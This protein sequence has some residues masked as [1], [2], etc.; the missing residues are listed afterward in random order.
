MRNSHPIRRYYLIFFFLS[1]HSLTLAA[2]TI[3]SFSLQSF[4]IEEYPE[5]SSDFALLG[6]ARI[7]KNDV[8]FVNL[9]SRSISS[10]GQIVFKKPIKL[11]DGKSHEPLSFSTDFVFSIFPGYEEGNGDGLAFVIIPASELSQIFGQGFFG[12]SKDFIKIET[13]FVAVEFDTKMDENV[14]D[15][16]GNHVGVD[17]G[18]FVSVETSDLSSVGLKLNSGEKLQSWIDYEVGSRRLEIRLN[19]AGK[20]RPYE[21]LISY[22]I[23]LSKMWA[24]GEVFVGISSSSGNSTQV[25]SLYSWSFGSRTVPDGLHSQPLDPH[26]SPSEHEEQHVH[27]KNC[28]L[29]ILGGL[30]FATGCGTIVAFFV[31]L[32]WVV[33]FTRHPPG[34]PELQM[35]PVDFRYEK[36]DVA[37]EKAAYDLNTELEH[38]S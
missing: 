9:T 25:S 15:P 7:E 37:V 3:S 23:D 18:N 27:K 29:R 5:F 6:D 26:L 16:N 1:L 8:S 17:V 35:R 36:L 20:D 13:N 30:I 22:P 19:K 38:N 2:E 4:E 33:F 11:I 28:A 14:G 34:T 12:I 31:L 32:L 21:P 10:S 24:E